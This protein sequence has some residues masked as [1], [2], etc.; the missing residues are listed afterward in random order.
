MNERAKI[1]FTYDV[2]QLSPEGKI[3]SQQ[4]V[5]NK[6]INEGVTFFLESIFLND[7]QK[8]PPTTFVVQ[9]IET[10]YVPL[11]TD[12]FKTNAFKNYGIDFTL[13]DNNKKPFF[14]TFSSNIAD[15]IISSNEISYTF[16]EYKTITGACILL[17]SARNNNSINVNYTT[18]TYLKKNGI[19]VSS[20][21]FYTPVQIVPN[22]V[23]KLRL[24][25]ELIPA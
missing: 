2:K 12:V 14:I 6:M 24:N 23:L 5:R 13:W 16:T 11:P 3:I 21:L 19:L 18:S 10:D 22:G 17:G 9:F 1:G 15:N 7:R 25:F 8:T 4:K 20:A